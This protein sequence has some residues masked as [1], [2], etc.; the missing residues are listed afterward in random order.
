[1]STQRACRLL[2]LQRSTYYKKSVADPQLPLRMRIRELAFARPRFGYHR[3]H[4]LLRR[5]GWDVGKKRVHRLCRLEG[6]NLRRW[7]RKRRAFPGRVPPEP[8]MAPNECWSLDFVTDAL[9]DGRR[10]RILTVVDNFTREALAVDMDFS[11]PARRVT[12]VLNRVITDRAI[13][14]MLRTDNGPE[15]TSR[16]FDHWAHANRI[17]LDFIQPGRPMQNGFVESF[18]GR[19]RDLRTQGH[20]R[21]GRP[22]REGLKR[23][24]REEE[25]LRASRERNRKAR[26]LKDKSIRNIRT[27][28]N[29]ILSS[30]VEWGYLA[31]MPRLPK[32]KVDDPQW[33][34]YRAEEARLLV[35]AV[36]DEWE[37]AVLLFPL[38]TGAC[39]WCSDGLGTPRS[40]PASGTVTS[41]PERATATSGSSIFRERPTR[42]GHRSTKI[43]P[44]WCQQLAHRPRISSK[45]R[46]KCGFLVVTPSGIGPTLA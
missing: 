30:A 23:R 16:H 36:R 35:A 31:A 13:P 46:R 43:V 6:L 12:A 15:F 27:T 39:A 9:A 18:N 26:G 10:F 37:R 32:V 34:W 5:E 44:T 2:E 17:N 41:R 42:S 22:A 4:V 7:T 38:A 24:K 19:L 1:L 25:K 33:E 11:M 21:K 45:T 28:L 3:I 40:P 29:T 20:S 14:R 8:C